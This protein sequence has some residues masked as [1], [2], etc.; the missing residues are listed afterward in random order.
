MQLKGRICK[1]INTCNELLL[2]ECIVDGMFRGLPLPVLTALVSTFVVQT[3]SETKPSIMDISK[4]DEL[5]ADKIEYIEKDIINVVIETQI[6]NGIDIDK[7]NFKDKHFNLSMVI[8]VYFWC[9]GKSFSEIC[10]FTDIMEGTIV[11]IMLRLIETLLEIKKIGEIIGNKSLE[12]NMEECVSLVK[13][14]IVYTESLY[15]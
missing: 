5:L 6:E 10:K 4:I 12:E 13:R 2:T 3:R 11:R 9:K 7:Y 15:I 1:E 8:V 14:D